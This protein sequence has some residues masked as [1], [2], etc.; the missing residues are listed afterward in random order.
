LSSLI[1]WVSSSAAD[2]LNSLAARLR[3]ALRC[4]ATNSGHE[5]ILSR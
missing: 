4:L 2:P 1:T 3:T 5:S